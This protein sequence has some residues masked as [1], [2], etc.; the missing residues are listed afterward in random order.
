MR[1]GSLVA[2]S[3]MVSPDKV[4]ST[5][6]DIKNALLT[7]DKTEKAKLYKDAQETIYK[8]APWAPLVTE[9][10][11]SANNKKL[12]GVHTMPDGSFNFTEV[13]LK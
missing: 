10:L 8:D 4:R 9:K 13:D 12:T 2:L 5:Y 7:T 3:T 1:I 11:L 6:G